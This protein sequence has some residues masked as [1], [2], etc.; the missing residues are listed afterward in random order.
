MAFDNLVFGAALVVSYTLDRRYFFLFSEHARRHRR[1]R[2]VDNDTNPNNNGQN[3]KNN[4]KCLVRQ[5][6][7]AGGERDPLEQSCVSPS[8][9]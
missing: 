7:F 9:D 3:T 4:I 6:G 8:Q 1:V 5:E 2:H